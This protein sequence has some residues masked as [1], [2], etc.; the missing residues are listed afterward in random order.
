MTN[1]CKLLLFTMILVVSYGCVKDEHSSHDEST[2]VDIGQLAPDFTTELID[3]TRCQLSDLRNNTVM[4]IF[5]SS[6]CPDCHA[7]FADL[8]KRISNEDPSFEILAISRAESL[9]ETEEFSKQYNLD[10]AVGLD[11]DKSIYN[12]YATMYV[13]RSFLIDTSGHI[14]DHTVEYSSAE[15]DAL[16][17]KAQNMGE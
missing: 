11:P 12:M 2:L 16:W 15:F 14:I 6:S 4:L 7:Q 8:A 9:E 10:F 5:F 1:W 13:P 17:R 3:G